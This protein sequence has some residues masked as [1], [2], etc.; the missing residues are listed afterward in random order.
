MNKRQYKKE[1][2]ICKDDFGNKIYA[3]DEVE[4]FTPISFRKP[5]TSIVYYD[6]LHGAMVKHKKAYVD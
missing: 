1:Y 3:G 2:F 6:R 4:I 5:W